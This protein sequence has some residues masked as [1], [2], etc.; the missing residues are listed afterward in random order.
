MEGF[1]FSLIPLPYFFSPLTP[2]FRHPPITKTVYSDNTYEFNTGHDTYSD[3]NNSI[4]IKGTAFNTSFHH[5][6][7]M[8]S[9]FSDAPLVL[10]HHNKIMY[11]CHHHFYHLRWVLVVVTGHTCQCPLLLPAPITLPIA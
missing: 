6:F 9:W 8:G 2:F 1:I 10:I 3:T 4:I 7:P 11:H 5:A